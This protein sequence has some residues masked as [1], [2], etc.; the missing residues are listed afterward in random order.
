[1]KRVNH[2]NAKIYER[3]DGMKLTRE[4]YINYDKV[5]DN[6]LEE[7][8]GTISVGDEFEQWKEKKI[9]DAYLNFDMHIERFKQLSRDEFNKELSKLVTMYN[10]VELFD[11]NEVKDVVGC[12]IIVLDEYKQLYIGST[13]KCI[14]RRVLSHWTNREAISRLVFG[15]VEKSILSVDSFRAYDTTKI[16]YLVTD[17]NWNEEES[18]VSDALVKFCLNRTAGGENDIGLLKSVANMRQLD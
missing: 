16:F 12:Y 9:K 4:N 2:F 7:S 5:W 10:F 3:I 14:K 18:M 13:S 8:L 17:E 15:S 11:L 1:M 6:K